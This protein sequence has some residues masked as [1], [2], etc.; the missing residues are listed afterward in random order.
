MSRLKVNCL[1]LRL[2]LQA[3]PSRVRTRIMMLDTFPQEGQ[4]NGSRMGIR[5]T[6]TLCGTTAQSGR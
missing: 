3:R 6:T 4:P 5:T 2:A 1:T